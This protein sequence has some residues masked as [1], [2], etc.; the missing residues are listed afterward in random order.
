MKI[1]QSGYHKITK[2]PT[3]VITDPI[4]YKYNNIKKKK[5]DD[6]E[7]DNKNNTTNNNNNDDGDDDDSNYNNNNNN[8]R[9]MMM[10]LTGATGD[11]QVSSHCT[12]SC[13]LEA[14]P[15]GD[16]VIMHKSHT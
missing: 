13:P 8:N 9:T 7:D 14:H 4:K 5:K 1:H 16:S 6:D 15:C 2:S 12:T 10:T 3:E 11:F